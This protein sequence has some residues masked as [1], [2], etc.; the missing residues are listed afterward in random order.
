LPAKR[1]LAEDMAM[2]QFY[3]IF[4]LAALLVACA[5]AAEP[6]RYTA[7]K[8]HTRIYFTVDHMGLSSYRGRFT[9]FDI[10][11]QF[12]EDKLS[13]SKVEVT[14]PVS[15]IDTFSPELNQKMPNKMFFDA[16][17]FPV[18][19]FV[20]TSVRPLGDNSVEMTGDLSM[21]GVTL[22]IR[23]EVMHNKTVSHPRF[24]LKNAG[25][26]ATGEIDS[27]AFGVNRLPDWMVGPVV[28]VQ[29]EMEAFEGDSIPYYSE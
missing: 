21:K 22:P 13:N 4:L 23:F 3:R 7:D 9:E 17:T 2:N 5:A 12:D 19:H 26:S 18:I 1:T 14:I 24:N 15:S 25:F 28:R 27:A 6:V 29:I 16:E 8:W 10:D 20:S 11:F